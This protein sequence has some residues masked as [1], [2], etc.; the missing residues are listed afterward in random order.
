MSD[1]KREVKVNVED[2]EEIVKRLTRIEE[3]LERLGKEQP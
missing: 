2:L 3:R 1:A